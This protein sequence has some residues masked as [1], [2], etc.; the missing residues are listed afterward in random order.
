MDDVILADYRWVI[1]MADWCAWCQKAKDLLQEHGEWPLY[2]DV[3]DPAV[4]A[5][6]V[7]LDHK[8]IPQVYHNGD[9]IGGY[10]ALQTFLENQG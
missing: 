2:L 3:S 6:L 5:L 1:F 4:K 8:T 10:E 7:Y 9:L